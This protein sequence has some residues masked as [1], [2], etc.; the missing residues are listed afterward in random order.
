[1]LNKLNIGQWQCGAGLS[2][3][4][5]IVLRNKRIARVTIPEPSLHSVY[6]Y[7]LQYNIPYKV[8]IE[9]C[10]IRVAKCQFFYTEQNP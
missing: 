3:A 8:D 4:S 1:M 7:I 10:Y 6:R 9:A 2:I 5:G